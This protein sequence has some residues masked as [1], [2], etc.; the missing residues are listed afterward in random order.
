MLE[1]DDKLHSGELM[2]LRPSPTQAE[3]AYLRSDHLSLLVVSSKRLDCLLEPDPHR[4]AAITADIGGA[5]EAL[6]LVGSFFF[7]GLFYD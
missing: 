3:S 2:A 1:R 6:W 5:T 4:R 7:A